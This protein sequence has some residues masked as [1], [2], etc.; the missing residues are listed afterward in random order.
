MKELIRHIIREHT[1]EIGEQKT[2]KWDKETVQQIANKYEFRNDFKKNDY[3]AYQAA[4]Y[5]GW[6]DEVTSHM[7]KKLKSWDKETVMDLAKNYT[8]MNDFIKNHPQAYNSALGR[9]WIEDLQKIMV[10]A[11]EKWN[12]DKVFQ[13]ALKYNTKNDFRNNSKK[14]YDAAI[15]HGW[16]DEVTAHMNP[17]LTR[18]TKEMAHQEALKY[19]NRSD[20]MNNSRNAY[21][22]AVS[23]KWIDDIT[24]HMEYLGNLFKRLVYVYEF[25]DKS[26]YVG[27]TMNKSER[28]R[29]HKK[30]GSKS[31]V[32]KHIKETGLTPEYKI[33]SDDY[34]DASD[35]Q[36]LEKCTIE[37]YKNDGWNVLNK[38]KAGGL[39]GR[40]LVSWTL[41]KTEKEALKYDTITK[42]SEGSRTAFLTAKRNG[43]IPQITQHMKVLKIK[44]T[45]E[46]LY[47][48]MSNYKTINDFRIGDINSFQ[49]ANRILGYDKIKS[50]YDK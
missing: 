41:D 16:Y 37:K 4:R 31:A 1:K 33:I 48:I 20:F 8:K 40:C 30:E 10:P 22:S 49:A 5:N 28:D 15:L 14:A 32:L 42:F 44:R 6:Y 46:S 12:K 7:G 36:N 23:N 35:A 34:I 3:S 27:L 45:P 26:V 29:T 25:P 13:E 2:R 47:N 9:G 18:W 39:G 21:Q 24:S 43:W 38:A 19:N 50:F 17:L 11:Y